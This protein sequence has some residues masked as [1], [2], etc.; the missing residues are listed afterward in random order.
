MRRLLFV[1]FDLSEKL[2]M[3]NEKRKGK[4]EPSLFYLYS[5]M[6]IKE[7]IRPEILQFDKNGCIFAGNL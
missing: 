7:A 2:K 1:Q 6:P 4:M 3:K 5:L